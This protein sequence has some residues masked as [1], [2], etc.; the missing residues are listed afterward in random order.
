VAAIVTLRLHG[1]I[2]VFVIG[3]CR[4]APTVGRLAGGDP[5][6]DFPRPAELV[7]LIDVAADGGGRHAEMLLE[8]PHRSEGRLAQ[9]IDDGLVA[10][11][12][13]HG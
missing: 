2:A 4:K 8:I 6:I 3:F 13:V 11:G 9:K 1:D 5:A 7:Q 10:L 12:V